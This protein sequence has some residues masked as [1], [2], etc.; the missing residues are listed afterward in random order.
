M[1]FFQR[2]TSPKKLTL[3]EMWK[4]YKLLNG[5]FNK[6]Y[7]LDEVVEMLQSIP[8]ENIRIVMRMFYAKFPTNPIEFGIKFTE[9]LKYNHFFEFQSVMENMNVSRHRIS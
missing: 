5:G 7:V 6:K 2:N 1:A 8:P 9:G 3:Q 4:V